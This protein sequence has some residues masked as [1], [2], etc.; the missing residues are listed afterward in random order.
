MHPVTSPAAPASA[1]TPA[2]SADQPLTRSR[3]LRFGAVIVSLLADRAVVP[4]LKRQGES[5]GCTNA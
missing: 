2:R 3:L 4:A 1:H 5:A